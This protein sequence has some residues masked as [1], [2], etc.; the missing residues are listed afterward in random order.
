MSPVCLIIVV[1]DAAGLCLS[2]NVSQWFGFS[3]IRTTSA[4]AAVH[5]LLVPINHFNASVD[6]PLLTIAD[7]AFPVAAARVWIGLA[8]QSHLWC[9][10][11]ACYSQLTQHAP[12]AFRDVIPL[13]L[14]L[15]SDTVIVG[16]VNRS[17]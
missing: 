6:C 5:A 17:C 1:A 4:T 9:T 14:C 3:A 2:L 13:L 10:V 16:H 12:A 11:S 8:Q 7:R 15:K